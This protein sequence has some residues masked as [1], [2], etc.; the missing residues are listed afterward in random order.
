MEEILQM[1]FT[2]CAI[3]GECVH[4]DQISKARRTQGD[5]RI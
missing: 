4:E 1:Y 5:K 2:V 3:L